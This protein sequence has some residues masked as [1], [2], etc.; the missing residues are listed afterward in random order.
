MDLVTAWKSFRK[1]VRD[2]QEAV[3]ILNG[4]FRE[5]TGDGIPGILGSESIP[6]V[7]EQTHPLDRNDKKE[8]LSLLAKLESSLSEQTTAAILDGLAPILPVFPVV[9]AERG[10][11]RYSD[12]GPCLDLL[13]DV[14]RGFDDDVIRDAA[15]GDLCLRVC[16]R[17][18]RL[19]SVLDP[20]TLLEDAYSTHKAVVN[21]PPSEFLAVAADESKDGPKLPPVRRRRSPGQLN[22]EMLNLMMTNTESRGWSSPQWARELKAHVKQ[23]C[24]QPAWKE[25]E[26]YR[27]AERIKRQAAKR[28]G[29]AAK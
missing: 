6:S 12:I 29:R 10:A 9:D 11:Y 24:E 7:W 20:L 8:L 19:R 26:A 1:I 18:L 5:S 13:R 17:Y 27:K 15:D 23:I 2:A 3:D 25:L 28:Q 21:M 16:P 4:Y 22:G 14:V